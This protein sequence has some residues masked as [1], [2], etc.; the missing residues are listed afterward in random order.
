MLILPRSGG[1]HLH[2]YEAERGGRTAVDVTSGLISGRVQLVADDCGEDV[3]TPLDF[4][5]VVEG[6]G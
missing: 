1:V 2:R 4:L 5:I 6:V 3:D